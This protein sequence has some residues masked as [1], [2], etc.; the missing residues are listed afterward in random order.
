MG[1]MPTARYMELMDKAEK[2][3]I[4][5]AEMRELR[6]IGGEWINEKTSEFQRQNP[7]RSR[8]RTHNQETPARCVLQP[9]L[10]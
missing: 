2:R 8:L 1:D 3:E 10:A 5:P 9:A 6:E 4:T 7:G